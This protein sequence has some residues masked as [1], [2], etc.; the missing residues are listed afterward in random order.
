M[1]QSP[2]GAQQWRRGGR[3]GGG[4]RPGP[5]PC[6]FFLR[7]AC[8]MG[9]ACRFSHDLA[10]LAAVALPMH[11]RQAVQARAGPGGAASAAVGAAGPS[12][13]GSGGGGGSAAAWR[14]RVMSY[15]VLADCLAHEHAAELYT[16]A[17]RFSLEWG[18]RSALILR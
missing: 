15:N 5:P 18:Y 7:G 14:F 1:Q 12:S 2:G 8:R 10:D 9:A 17:P 6:I 16:S 3:G 4:G 13:S 11:H